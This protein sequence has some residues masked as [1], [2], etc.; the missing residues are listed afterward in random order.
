M[1]MFPIYGRFIGDFAAHLVAVDTEDTIG[2]AAAKIAAHSIGRRLPT[3]P[4][5]GY[6]V[7]VDGR[8]IPA[9]VRLTDLSLRPLQWIDVR[10]KR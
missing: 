10:W 6:E 5:V 8:V 2:E 1:V 7:L 3:E 9:E 4:A